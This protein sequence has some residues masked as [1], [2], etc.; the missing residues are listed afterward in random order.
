LGPMSEE[1]RSPGTDVVDVGVP[2]DVYEPR[3]LAFGDEPGRPA[4]ASKGANRRVN[5]TGS[6]FLGAS[7]KL[8]GAR[9][10]HDCYLIGTRCWCPE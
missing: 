7:E 9:V 10:I 1:Q 5:A 4:D 6:D 2:V 8:V 3:S